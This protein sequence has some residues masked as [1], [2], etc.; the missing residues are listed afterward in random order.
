MHRRQGPRHREVV[1]LLHDVRSPRALGRNAFVRAEFVAQLP[2]L[3]DRLIDEL[4]AE[5]ELQRR[6]FEVLRRSDVARE[7]Q[8][9]V[10]ADLGLSRSQFYRDLHAA[11]RLFAEALEDRLAARRSA[12]DDT[13]FLAIEVLRNGG[14]YDRARDV[15]SAVARNADAADAIRVLCLRAELEIESG[16]FAQ[17]RLTAGEARIL[18]SRIEDARL[19]GLLG[20]Q[21]ELVEFEAAHCQ[22]APAVPDRRSSLIDELRRSYGP[23]DREY[24]ALLVKALIEEASMLFEQNDSTRAL[25]SI[26]E[27]SSIVAHERLSDTRLAIDVKIRASGIH[28]VE[29]DRV[30]VALDETV[31]I[32]DM[33]RRNGD[34]RTLRVGMQMMSAHLLTLGRFDEARH[35]ALEARTLID[36]FGSTLDR[37]IV[38]SN[39]AHRHPP[40]RRHRRAGLD[41]IGARTRVQRVFDH[42]RARDFGSRGDGAAES[43]HPS[44]RNDAFAQ[45]SR[46]RVA[47]APRPSQIGRSG[48]AGRPGSGSPRP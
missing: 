26:E 33:G 17:A 31:E 12:D 1:A 23:Q 27:A 11:R 14:Q 37:A 25:A 35:F 46:A 44:G 13:R 18:L 6:R 38:L 2:G 47:A 16:S 21:C 8:S 22:G 10:A 45:R 15:A 20:A 30:A 48:R 9:V 19:R 40:P 39:L 5:S 4:G 7:Q 29:P 24:A 41:P 34:V 36:L 43:T 32:V 28:A 3:V 42:A